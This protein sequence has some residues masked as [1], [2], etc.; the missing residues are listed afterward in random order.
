M[1][2]K[3]PVLLAG[4]HTLFALSE[5]VCFA[6]ETLV[7]VL[8]DAGLT[9]R[10]AGFTFLA[11]LVL[12]VADGAFI[13]TGVSGCSSD[14]EICPDPSIGGS[15][16]DTDGTPHPDLCTGEESSDWLEDSGPPASHPPASH[17]PCSWSRIQR[18]VPNR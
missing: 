13:H 1:Q 7:A 14:S 18:G 4:L 3:V 2:V 11:R 9:G 16:C 17:P 6:D 8:P 5:K 10:V 15:I 12:I